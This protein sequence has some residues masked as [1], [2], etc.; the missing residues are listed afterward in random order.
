MRCL[1]A[2]QRGG[3]AKKKSKDYGREREREREKL[4]ENCNYCAWTLISV[5]ATN[6]W[7]SGSYIFQ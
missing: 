1:G 6:S 5:I 4:K 7:K 2:V 3:N